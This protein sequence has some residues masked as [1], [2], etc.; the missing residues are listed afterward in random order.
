MFGIS[1]ALS[2]TGNVLVVGAY[3]EDSA[4]TGIGG[5]QA[6]NA[7]AASGALY[8]FSRVGAAW[9]QLSYVKAP[10]ANAND[11]FG[12]AI[13]VSNDGDTVAAGSQGEDSASLGIGG[14][15]SDESAAASGA[16]YL[17]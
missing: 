15:Q 4:A 14:S 9:S 1:V 10:N 16:V 2:G 12:S 6:D 8:V 7:A 11:E 5:N 13:A 3:G 17:F